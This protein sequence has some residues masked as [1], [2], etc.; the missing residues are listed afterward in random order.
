M[1]RRLVRDHAAEAC[2]A[3]AFVDH[4]EVAEPGGPVLVEPPGDPKPIAGRRLP[5]HRLRVHLAPAGSSGELAG[6]R[7]TSGRPQE[8]FH[9][10]Q[11]GR[12]LPNGVDQ[13]VRDRPPCSGDVGTRVAWE[14]ARGPFFPGALLAAPLGQSLS[15]I[16]R[17]RRRN[18]EV[19]FPLSSSY[20]SRNP[21]V[22]ISG[23]SC[24]A[25]SKH[26]RRPRGPCKSGSVPGVI[27]SSLHH[28]TRTDPLSSVQRILASLSRSGA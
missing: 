2:C 23:S 14:F 3:V 5:C 17:Q 10:T 26:K 24:I 18:L 12:D 11:R 9:E 19:P 7:A 15:R 4:G 22:L 28:R 21:A 16:I 1:Q 20:A 6:S 25:S 27:R 13:S 8:I